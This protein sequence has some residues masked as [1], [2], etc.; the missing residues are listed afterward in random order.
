MTR[1]NHILSSALLAVGLLV[2]VGSSGC[3]ARV[4]YYDTD[5]R[6]YHYWNHDEDI[7]YHRYWDDRHQPY[8]EYRGLNRD[9]QRDYWNWRH[10]HNDHD[11]DRDDR[12]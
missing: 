6:D 12:H 10:N 9:E 3:A 2:A 4:R 7:Y 8:R 11:H 1:T 5:H